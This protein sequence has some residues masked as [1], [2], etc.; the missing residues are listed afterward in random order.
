M[1]REEELI[2]TGRANMIEVFLMLLACRTAVLVPTMFVLL[3]V[4]VAAQV[5]SPAAPAEQP[6]GPPASSFAPASAYAFDVV[7]IKPSDPNARGPHW[8]LRRYRLAGNR[9]PSKRSRLYGLLSV[10]LS[11]E[12]DHWYARMGL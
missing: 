8:R 7:S 1:V 3:A 11:E 9:L 4:T 10:E 2:V 5:A 6:A 12:P